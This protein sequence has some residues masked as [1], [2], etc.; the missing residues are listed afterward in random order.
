MKNT[1]EEILKQYEKE[2]KK[3]TP[4]RTDV[5]S[6]KEDVENKIYNINENIIQREE[7]QKLRLRDKL[8][9]TVSKFIWIQLIFFNLVVL[10][11]VLA[12]TSKFEYFKIINNELATLLFDF[13]KYYI[14]A[15]IVELLGM[16]VFIL[17]YVF[18]KYSGIDK[19]N[20]LKK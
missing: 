18:S 14:S 20:K 17:H 8:T 10:I 9:K 13:L 12:V 3:D 1:I 2:I 5:I 19:I 15:T 7:S 16:L 6:T 4:T 11:I